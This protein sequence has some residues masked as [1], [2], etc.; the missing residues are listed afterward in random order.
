MNYFALT[1]RGLEKFAEH[2]ITQKLIGSKIKNVSYRKVIFSFDGGYKKILNLRAIEDVFYFIGTLENIKHTKCS[3]NDLVNKIC[4]LDFHKALNFISNFRQDKIKEFSISSSSIGKRN[5][6]YIEVKENLSK[7]L[8]KIL[9]LQYEDERHSDF[10]IRIFIEHDVAIV[11]IRLGNKPL[12]RRS[13]KIKTTKATLQADIAYV[14]SEIAEI[15]KDNIILDPMCGSGT[16]LIES[17]TFNPKKIIGSDI[18]KEALEASKIN[19]EN[20]NSNLQIDLNNWD[21]ESLPIDDN[22]IDK[23]ICNLPFGKQIKINSMDLFY[24]K[25]TSEFNRVLKKDGLIILLTSNPEILKDAIRKNR[26][27]LKNEFEISVNGE[28]ADICVIGKP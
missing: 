17:S 5:Y 2:E 19:I 23:I 14:M 21:S 11:G 15:K 3:L 6:S 12:Y 8:E 1:T 10:D 26:L 16:I 24:L 9:K 7:R 13:Y 25:I 18:N 28:I 20:F 22:S 4:L 27:I